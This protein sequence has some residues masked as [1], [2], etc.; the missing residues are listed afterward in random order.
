MH[1]NRQSRTVLRY[2]Q[3]QQVHDCWVQ[4]GEDEEASDSEAQ[5]PVDVLTGNRDHDKLPGG[6][7]VVWGGRRPEWFTSLK[8][9]QPCAAAVASA[10]QST[11]A[12]GGDVPDR[13]GRP[14]ALSDKQRRK[15]L[16]VACKMLK[17][18]QG[19]IKL[20]EVVDSALAALNVSQSMHAA[21][22]R[23][24]V[25]TVIKAG[26]GWSVQGG[27]LMAAIAVQS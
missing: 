21:K 19:G 14:L 9:Q 8:Q 3:R 13:A 16:K 20:K 4:E 24:K 23:S 11:E 22:L 7:V 2:L 12:K 18:C 25:K 6:A 17:K 27:K 5:E 26:D 1:E 15:C 10:A